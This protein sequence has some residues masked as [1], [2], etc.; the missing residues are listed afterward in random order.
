MSA[1]DFSSGETV[2]SFEPVIVVNFV[3]APPSTDIV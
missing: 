1:S 3:R 2:A